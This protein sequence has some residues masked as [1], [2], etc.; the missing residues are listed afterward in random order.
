MSVGLS[1]GGPKSACRVT[2]SAAVT[3]FSISPGDNDSTS[4]D[5]VEPVAGVVLR[6]IVGRPDVDAQQ[7]LDRVV[8]LGAVEPPGGDA[9]RIRTALCDRCARAR[10][11]AISRPPAGVL[12]RLLLFDRRHFASPAAWRRPLP[13]GRPDRRATPRRIERLEVQAVLRLLVAVAGEQFLATNGLTRVSKPAAGCVDA[14]AGAGLRAAADGCDRA[15]SGA[16]CAAPTAAIEDRRTTTRSERTHPPVIR[17]PSSGRNVPATL[18]RLQIMKIR[19]GQIK[20]ISSR[21]R[22]T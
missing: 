16:F 20:P 17:N 8:V 13:S 5:V 9:A 14:G 2:R 3:Y 6:E 11:P 21:R 18:K 12:R 7:V 1:V 22:V 15:G 19:R 4:R 10:S